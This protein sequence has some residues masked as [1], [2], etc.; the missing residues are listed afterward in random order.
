MK[1]Y[2]ALK[3]QNQLCFPLYAASREIVKRY[4]PFLSRYDLTYTQY[5][6][7]LVL[8]EVKKCTV[9]ELGERLYLDSGTLTPVLKNLQQK[10]YLEKNRSKQDER[11]VE[12]EITQPGMA[13]R[14]QL[15]DIPAKLGSCVRLSGEEAK[16]LY[17][18]LYKI[19]GTV[20]S[21]GM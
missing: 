6:V 10:G 2:E 5:I 19:L 21:G 11:V 3:L 4:H 20:E 13:L 14:E 7:L 9:K 18:L 1:E 17:Q 15:K 16:T 8:W 12:V